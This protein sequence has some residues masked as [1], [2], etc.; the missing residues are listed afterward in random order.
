MPLI[1]SGSRAAV[2]QNISE[3]V[4]AGHPQKQAVAAALSNARKYGH[5]AGGGVQMP[6]AERFAARQVFHEGFL[7]S[8]VPGRTDKLPISVSGGAYVL[9]ADHVAALGQGNSLA[10]ANIVNKMFKMGPYGSQ[11]M[12]MHAARPQ[13]PHL[14][15]NARAAMPHA[16]GGD[17]HD[18][19]DY[20]RATNYI[21]GLTSLG[22][23]SPGESPVHYAGRQTQ[24][25]A[26]DIRSPRPPTS[27]AQGGHGQGK[28]TPIIAAGGEIVI[29]PEKIIAK[30]GDLKHGHKALDQWVLD[31]RE[32][33][34][35]TLR[36]LKPPKQD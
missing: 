22:K 36:K 5:A 28:P 12:P 16:D 3:M 23:M 33:H 29:P 9:P 14:N 21:R 6:F 17:V 20:A 1:K 24:D 30:F 8:A 32:Q 27:Y 31:T 18:S 25:L 34:I 10:G 13:I 35:K 19:P 4:H 15:L 2:S 7:H 11:Q 26:D